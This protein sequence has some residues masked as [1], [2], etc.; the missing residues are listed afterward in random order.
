ML[1]FLFE[2]QLWPAVGD[3]KLVEQLG[4]SGIVQLSRMVD[5]RKTDEE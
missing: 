2:T 1:E 3:G 5:I 4:A